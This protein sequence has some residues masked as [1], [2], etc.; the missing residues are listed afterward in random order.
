MQNGHR[1]TNRICMKLAIYTINMQ[2]QLVINYKNE[3][4]S[5]AYFGAA[6]RCIG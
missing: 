6:E 2:Y 5:L 3:K 4:F 1:L